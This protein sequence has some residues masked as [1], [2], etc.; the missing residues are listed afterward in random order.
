[1]QIETFGVE[2]WMNTHETTA[3]WN[4][5]ETCVDSL[6][7]NELL[8]L[9]G[10]SQTTIDRLLTTKLTYG[11]IPGSL[12]LRTAIAGLYD[13]PVDPEMVLVAN[14]A[15]G[16][17]FLVHFALVEAG[18]SVVCVS[19]TYQQL[20]SVPRA[21]GAESRILPLRPEQGYVPDVGELESLVDDTTRLIVINN[22]NNPTGALMDEE[23]LKAVVAVAERRGAFV[24]CDEV[25]RGLEHDPATRAPSIVSLYDRGISTG[26]AS[27]TFSLAGLRTGWIVAPPQVLEECAR[28]R[29]YTTISCGA[30]DDLLATV[31]MLNADK[32]LARN[33]GIVTG[34]LA[35]LEEW[36][37][38]EPALHHVSPRAGTTS[39]IHYDY[40]VP[41]ERFCQE[42]FDL[43]GAFVVPGSRFDLERCYRIGYACS[44]EQLEGGLAAT[45]EYLRTLE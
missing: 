28:R 25:Y 3:R 41:S 16:A 22:P 31:A 15:I 39:L 44:R 23:L 42:L 35:V 19:P 4:N 30:I 32:I 17:N 26:S 38:S 27:K 1:M 21:F 24:H 45:S 6:R 18:D 14:G 40:D 29:D 20:Y 34:N 36:L 7:V 8:E 5:A 10:E 9:V 37:R 2:Q 13:E 11:A 33:L 12:E 43:N